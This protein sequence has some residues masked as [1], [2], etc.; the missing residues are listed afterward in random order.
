MKLF[1]DPDSPGRWCQCYCDDRGGTVRHRYIEEEEGLRI[2]G[3]P[4][5][6]TRKRTRAMLGAGCDGHVL[7]ALQSAIAPMVH[8]EAAPASYSCT[9][10]NTPSPLRHARFTHPGSDAERCLGWGSCPSFF[11]DVCASSK[12]IHTPANRTPVEHTN[13]VGAMLCADIIGPFTPTVT[14]KYKY[15]AVYVSAF[16]KIVSTYPMQRKSDFTAATDHLLLKYREK[17]TPVRMFMTDY[18]PVMRSTQFRT[19]ASKHGVSVRYSSPYSHWQNGLIERCIYT[20][21]NKTICNL[22]QSGLGAEWWYPAL[23]HAASSHNATP[24]RTNPAAASPPGWW[25]S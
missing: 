11:C 5:A 18:D 4:L 9:F 16:G 24:T 19:M 7:D 1:N 17:G 2:A 3:F 8:D 20:L 25:D 10:E 22:Q 21:K 14:N 6:S 23:S 13:D 12:C 15:A